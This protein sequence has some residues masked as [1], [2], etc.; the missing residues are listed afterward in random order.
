MRPRGPGSLT[1]RVALLAALWVVA[2]LV[3][4][5]WFVA[6]FA[7]RSI[8]AGADARLSASLDAVIAAVAVDPQGQP[9]LDR[10]PPD[11]EFERP[12]SGQYWQVTGKGGVARSRSLWDASLPTP[13]PNG[14][15][16]GRPVARDA[17]GPRGEGLRL[18]ERRIEL[19]DQPQPLLV[20]V[21]AS[22]EAMERELGW[23][24]RGL[25]IAFGLLGT[26]LVAGVAA[27]VVWAMRP[28]R[29]ARAALAAVREGERERLGLAAPAEI[30][31]LVEE[32]DALIAQ[33]R[34]TVERAR[35]HIGNLAHALKTPA[36]VLNNALDAVSGPGAEVARAQAGEIERILRHH[37]ARARASALAGAATGTVDA[38]AV[39]EEVAA[40]LRRLQGEGGVIIA[41]L[42]EAGLRLRADRQDLVEMLGNLIENACKWAA[43]RVEVRLGAAGRVAVLEV[44]DDGPGLPEGQALATGRGIRLDESV[45][46]TG[47][48]LAIVDDLAGLHGGRLVLAPGAQLGG[49][50]ARLE[51]PA[52]GPGAAG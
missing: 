39:V 20:Q 31:P 5:G 49:L 48:G 43:S 2:G 45:P 33:N 13:P 12:L 18:L 42:G 6:G 4:T 50:C 40:A 7:G 34:A 19:P 30:A 44:E 38:R 22:R 11:P 41:V 15:E 25:A 29:E 9:R 1:R 52:A 46:G 51:L 8:I 26:G 14:E 3:L 17:T 47:L 32:V 10:S 36:A 37:L 21:A 23:L 27:Q 35:A 16:A 24:R 28:L